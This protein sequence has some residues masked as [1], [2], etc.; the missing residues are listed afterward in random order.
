MDNLPFQCWSQEAPIM[1]SRWYQIVRICD[2][3]QQQTERKNLIIYSCIKSLGTFTYNCQQQWSSAPL[4]CLCNS[5][6]KLD[7]CWASWRG[8]L[9]PSMFVQPENVDGLDIQK[10]VWW[11]G[12]C[13][14]IGLQTCMPWS[15]FKKWSWWH[16]PWKINVSLFMT[17]FRDHAKTN[18]RQN[19]ATY[20]MTFG[21]LPR[22]HL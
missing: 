17:C 20:T 18:Q 7:N 3:I 2:S 21:T 4:F 13:L 10:M 1:F 12:H 9:C 15:S 19:V 14:T 16:H 6:W 5:I 22:H 11:K 8:K